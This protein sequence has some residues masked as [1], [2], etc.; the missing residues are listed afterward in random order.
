MPA[1]W[2]EQISCTIHK[3]CLLV[4]GLVL[5]EA[6]TQDPACRDAC[7]HLNPEMEPVQRQHVADVR[8]TTWKL[9]LCSRVM[10]PSLIF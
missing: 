10:N 7:K 8:L 9:V 5:L 1:L 6:Y 3:Y 2:Q 4:E